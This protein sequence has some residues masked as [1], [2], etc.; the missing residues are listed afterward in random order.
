VKNERTPTLE[1]PLV[2]TDPEGLRGQQLGRGGPGYA[3]L[4]AELSRR[5]R[6]GEWK[7]DERVPS[8]RELCDRYQVSRTLVRQALALAER[9]GLLVRVPGKGTF[10][11]RPRIIQELSRMTTFRTTL[12]HLELAPARRVLRCDWE[13]PPSDVTVQL[14][15]PAST[16]VLYLEVVGLAGMRP[17]AL[18]QSYIPPAVAKASMLEQRVSSGSEVGGPSSYEVIGEALG[19]PHLRADQLYETVN[20]DDRNAAALEL[21]TN[22]A[23]FKVITLFTTPDDTPVESRVALYPG[24]RYGFHI[25]RTVALREEGD[26]GGSEP[27]PLAGAKVFMT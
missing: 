14:R 19:V 12:A 9:D 22:A 15:L 2:F 3:L 13:I 18:Y 1:D 23:A 7:P 4:Y 21:P 25:V 16:Q 24:D 27:S 11:A 10:V 17:L 5:I 8:E 20:L 26:E 6:S